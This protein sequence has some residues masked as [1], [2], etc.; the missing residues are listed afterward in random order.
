MANM[1]PLDLFNEARLADALAAQ[2]QIVAADPNDV[3][4]QLL[5]CEF[6]AY[7]GLRADARKRLR[8][9]RPADAAMQDYLANWQHVLHADN[10]RHNQRTPN[11]LSEPPAAILQRLE[12]FTLVAAGQDDEALDALDA[13]DEAA[14]WLCGHVDGRPFEGLR[15][16]DDL[17]APVLEAFHADEFVWLP[18][19]QIRKLRM[20]PE[21]VLRDRLYRPAHVWLHDGSDW[22]VILPTLYVDSATSEEEG[23]QTGAGT[24]WVEAGPFMRGIGGKTILVGDEELLLGEFNQVEIQRP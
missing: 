14:D 9:L 11:F 16:A 10:V 21:E 15:D 20:A 17:L 24:D 2:R 5:L 12:V 8:A 13:M 7:A 1:S 4:A 19:M 23:I 6:L 18:W 22:E 3:A